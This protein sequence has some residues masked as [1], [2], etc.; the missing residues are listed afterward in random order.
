M[1][2]RVKVYWIYIA[3][4]HCVRDKDVQIVSHLKGLISGYFLL[5]SQGRGS[6]FKNTGA[7]LVSRIISLQYFPTPSWGSVFRGVEVERK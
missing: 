5:D 6:V 4:V 2:I 1:L 3:A 7:S